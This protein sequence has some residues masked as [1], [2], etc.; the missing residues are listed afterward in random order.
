MMSARARNDRVQTGPAETKLLILETIHP[1][2]VRTN[3]ATLK[4]LISRFDSLVQIG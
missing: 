1:A 4:Q 3:N 2:L